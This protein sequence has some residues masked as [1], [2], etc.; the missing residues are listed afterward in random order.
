MKSTPFGDGFA[1]SQRPAAEHAAINQGNTVA[2]PLRERY[3][4][5]LLAR[6][7]SDK[8]PS[9]EHM[10]LL[11]SVADDRTLVAYILHLLKK[12]E[13]DPN[14]SIPMMRRVQRLIDRFGR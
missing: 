10:A 12:I 7:S 4:A 5:V 1:R 6:I 14:P 11:E 9:A 2:N 8:H 13:N 3:A